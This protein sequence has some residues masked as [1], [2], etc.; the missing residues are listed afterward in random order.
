MP[1]TTEACCVTEGTRAAEP[2]TVPR[3]RLDLATV[4]RAVMGW[5]A[6]W[7]RAQSA[8]ELLTHSVLDRRAR[9]ALDTLL[10]PS[11]TK[12]RR[13]SRRDS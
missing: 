8:P 11:A 1:T 4:L 7:L 6:A 13:S 5:T 2:T 10:R 12:H 9:A 3:P